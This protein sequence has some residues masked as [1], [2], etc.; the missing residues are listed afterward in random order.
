MLDNEVKQKIRERKDYD[1]YFLLEIIDIYIFLLLEFQNTTKNRRELI[2]FYKEYTKYSKLEKEI[3]NIIK[4]S[5]QN[6]DTL[7]IGESLIDDIEEIYFKIF[8][9]NEWIINQYY[10]AM[11]DRSYKN[12]LIKE[13]EFGTFSEESKKE[14]IKKLNS[15]G[16]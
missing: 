14:L 13:K 12:I 16:G 15:Y 5:K 10:E 9:Y 6:S 7:E 2:N 11:K 4:N 1:K 8:N 3:L